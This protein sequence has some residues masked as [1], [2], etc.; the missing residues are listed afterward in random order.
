M[1]DMYFTIFNVYSGKFERVR[2][3]LAVY[4]RYFLPENLK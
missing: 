2:M 3:S 1:N 4:R